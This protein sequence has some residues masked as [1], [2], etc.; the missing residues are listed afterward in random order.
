MKK[1]IDYGKITSLHNAGWTGDKIAEDLGISRDE[2]NKALTDLLDRL[3]AKI[4]LCERQY[5]MVVGMLKN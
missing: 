2:Y 4:M 1:T 5:R 3:D